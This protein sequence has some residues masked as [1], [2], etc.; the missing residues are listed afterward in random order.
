[1]TTARG[2]GPTCWCA[3]RPARSSSSTPRPPV[4]AYFDAAR[5]GIAEEERAMHLRRHAAHIRA[6]VDTLTRKAYWDQFP[7]RAG[8]RGAIS[9]GRELLFRRARARSV[10]DRARRGTQDH[11]ARR[12]RRSS[13]FCARCSTAGGRRRLTKE[14]AVISELGRDLYRRLGTVGEHFS[15]VGA[16]LDAATRAYNQAVGSLE[17][18]VLV[19]AR[20]FRDLEAMSKRGRVAP[21]SVTSSRPRA[22]CRPGNC[23]PT[24]NR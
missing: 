18:R 8:I 13:R 16:G 2:C 4:D 11:P 1:M 19:T 5:D 9:A 15:K 24:S 22:N 7:R 10:A 3:C 20:K 6:H 23:G 21:P 12:R 14:A 17:G